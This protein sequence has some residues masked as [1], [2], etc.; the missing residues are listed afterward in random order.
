MDVIATAADKEEIGMTT[1]HSEFGDPVVVD[2]SAKNWQMV[3]FTHG[4]LFFIFC[5]YSYL[6]ILY[7]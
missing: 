2:D 4:K 3:R 6:F 1:R 5:F 7:S